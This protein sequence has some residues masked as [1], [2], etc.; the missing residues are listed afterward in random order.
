MVLA[1]S[2]SPGQRA[3][4]KRVCVYVS[5]QCLVQRMRTFSITL[6]KPPALHTRAHCHLQFVL[7]IRS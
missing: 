2:G 1:H 7:M 4:V 3:V 5:V 6:S